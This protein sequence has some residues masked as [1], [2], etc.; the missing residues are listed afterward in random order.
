MSKDH[1]SFREVYTQYVGAIRA[2]LA[3]RVPFADVDDLSAD[4]FAVAWK[5]RSTPNLGEELPWL[6]TIAS[7]VVANYR[8]KEKNRLDVF[9][10]ITR[11]DSAPAADAFL[12]GD[13]ELAVAWQA[14]PTPQ[15]EI[16]A[17]VVIDGVS[18]AEAATVM[19]IT[20]NALSIRLHR[21]KKNLADLLMTTRGERKETLET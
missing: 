8:R 16:L 3:R 11:P 17:L 21:A 14:L 4:V 12:E 18:V 20:P 2:Y 10:L 13:P 19:G 7:Y 6:Y 5:K 15:R 9:W 1:G